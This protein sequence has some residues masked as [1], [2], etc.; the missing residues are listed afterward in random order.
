MTY[1]QHK[2]TY[3][4]DA[5]LSCWYCGDDSIENA[6]LIEWQKG[7]EKQILCDKCLEECFRNEKNVKILAD[8]GRL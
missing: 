7:Y 8:I 6:S 2:I 5:V 3:R 4:D 1:T